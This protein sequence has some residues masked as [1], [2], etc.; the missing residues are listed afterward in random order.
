MGLTLLRRTRRDPSVLVP[1]D[2]AWQLKD[3]IS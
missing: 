3:L 1:L 2:G